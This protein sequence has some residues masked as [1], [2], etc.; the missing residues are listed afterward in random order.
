MLVAGVAC[1][2][3]APLYIPAFRA[4]RRR[5]EAMPGVVSTS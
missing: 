1:A 5:A 3:A 2:L 4:E